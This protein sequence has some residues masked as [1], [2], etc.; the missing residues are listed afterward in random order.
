M[1]SRSNSKF[2]KA[3]DLLIPSDHNG[4]GKRLFSTMNSRSMAPILAVFLAVMLLLPEAQA[5]MGA[6]GAKQ[7]APAVK[8]DL[9]YIRCSVCEEMVKNIHRDVKQ[10]RDE[11]GKKVCNDD[12]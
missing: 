4:L 2:Q 3:Q 5:Q 10:M 1:H 7:K 8:S 11:Q 6:G 12:A 9:K